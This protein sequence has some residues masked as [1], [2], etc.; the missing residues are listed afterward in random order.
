MYLNILLYLII[1]GSK[2]REKRT[3]TIN[4]YKLTCGGLTADGA[5]PDA[6]L[7]DPLERWAEAGADEC[8]DCKTCLRVRGFAIVLVVDALER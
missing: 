2:R 7:V 6:V 1:L 4:S 8:A 3:E 5:V